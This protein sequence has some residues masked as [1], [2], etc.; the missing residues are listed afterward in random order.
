[1]LHSLLFM[2][3]HALDWAKH[4]INDK[5]KGRKWREYKNCHYLLVTASVTVIS[6]LDYSSILLTSHVCFSPYLCLSLA[7]QRVRSES[8]RSIGIFPALPPPFPVSCYTLQIALSLGS[9]NTMSI[10]I[11]KC[12]VWRHKSLLYFAK[13]FFKNT[14]F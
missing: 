12:P 8:I 4:Y 6:C 13:K 1:M 14:Y 10:F 5:V 2:K 11:Y 7:V 3:A 9:T